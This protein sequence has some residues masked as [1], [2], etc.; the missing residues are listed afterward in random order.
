MLAASMNGMLL[1]KPFPGATACVLIGRLDHA[2]DRVFTGCRA[3]LWLVDADGTQP[4]PSGLTRE[5][6]QIVAVGSEGSAGGLSPALDRLIGRDGRHLPSLYVTPG[7]LGPHAAAYEAAVAEVHAA[8]EH[9]HRARI[10]RQRDGF[11]WQK[12]LL[13]NASAYL[14]RRLPDSWQNALCGL[15]AF[16]CGAGPSLDVS[17]PRLAPVAGRGVVFAAD[18]ALHALARHG[19]RVDIA[20]SIDAAKQPA[21]C[22]PATALPARVILSTVSPPAWRDAVPADR[23]FFVS[24]NQISEDWLCAQG[25]V[26]AAVP[27]QE[28]CA[29]TALGLARFLGCAPIH[30]L[31]LDLA[32]DPARPAQRHNAAADPTVYAASG[33]DPSR[34]LPTVPGNYGDRVPT[35]APG[36]WRALDARLA[37]WPAGLVV[38]VTDRGARFRNTTVLHP[39]AFSLDAS[40]GAKNAPLSG[41]SEPEAPP[42]DIAIAALA[43]LHA[44]GARASGSC[45]SLRAALAAGDYP[46]L[47]TIFRGFLS[48]NDSARAFGGFSFKLM[49]HLLPPV[50]N[51]AG[52]WQ[53]LVNEF[54]ELGDLARAA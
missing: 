15:P 35:F 23:C 21:K 48:D 42:P 1:E 25:V 52:L 8:L 43:R 32:V 22:L 47:A 38:N 26:R 10:T 29:S 30:L 4:F 6:V 54:E 17:A 9:H 51:D 13:Q 41:L 37:G 2:E 7:V 46:T 40:A 16:V 5:A 33:Y 34:P 27:V 28:N 20:V 36:D 49:P 24:G 18:S 14:Q 39:N 50:E 3:M 11:V 31:G 19:I 53:G 44:A 45:E 12:Y